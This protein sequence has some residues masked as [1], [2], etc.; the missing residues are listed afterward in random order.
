MMARS[1]GFGLHEEALEVAH[2]SESE[3]R[4]RGIEGVFRRDD[5]HGRLISDQYQL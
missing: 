3:S 5:R 1:R 2:F 4:I